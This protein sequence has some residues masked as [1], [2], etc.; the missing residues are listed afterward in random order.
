MDNLQIISSNLTKLEDLVESVN[1]YYLYASR[2]FFTNFG[3][4]ELENF[5]VMKKFL[6]KVEIELTNSSNEI[7]AYIL[8]DERLKEG[9]QFLLQE[10]N[11]SP[12]KEL[13]SL[14]NLK[15]LK[16]S[17]DS[18]ATQ[19]ISAV[20]DLLLERANIPVDMVQA[21][22]RYNENLLVFKAIQ[23]DQYEIMGTFSKALKLF[24]NYESSSSLLK[25][26]IIQLN[27]RPLKF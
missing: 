6:D 12:L 10:K 16:I 18:I 19:N 27:L 4:D 24:F 9:I 11:Y 22:S 17:T 1:T 21:L 5:K 2:H 3:E 20:K 14:S 7:M 26:H 15:T 23:T 25:N 13:S 8:K